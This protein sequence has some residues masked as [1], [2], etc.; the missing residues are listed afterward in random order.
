MVQARCRIG[1]T[2]DEP[3][4]PNAKQAYEEAKTV[5]EGLVD[6]SIALDQNIVD[7]ARSSLTYSYARASETVMSAAY[8]AYLDEVLKGVGKDSNKKLLEKFPDITLDQI[9]S[10][11][12]VYL[13]P[14]FSSD[15][16]IGA[17]T[18]STGKVDEVEQGFKE[19]GFEVER[20]TLPS[21]GG[22]EDGSEGESG[23]EETG[24]ESGSSR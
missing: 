18:V 7:G 4:S 1:I 23:D 5:L 24:S 15:S 11:I 17:V 6:G 19:L 9:R 10:A 14:I 3:K 21:L 8:T 13:V 22:E 12:K 20:R 16:A 2:A